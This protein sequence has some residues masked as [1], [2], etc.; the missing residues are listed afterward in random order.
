MNTSH[1]DT[2]MTH[3]FEGTPRIRPTLRSARRARPQGNRLRWVSAVAAALAIVVGLSALP[4]NSAAA[5]TPPEDPPSSTGVSPAEPTSA[6]SLSTAL[7]GSQSEAEASDTTADPTDAQRVGEPAQT[8]P[9][10]TAEPTD[11]LAAGEQNV[12]SLPISAEPTD[13]ASTDVVTTEPPT[14]E[15][16]P[17]DQTTS[18]A[19]SVE[20]AP[21]SPPTA[22]KLSVTNRQSIRVTWTYDSNG[23]SGFEIE[24]GYPSGTGW[25]P[26]GTVAADVFVFDDDVSDLTPGNLVA[27]RVRA[28]AGDAVSEWQSG[29]VLLEGPA[30]APSSLSEPECD[31]SYPTACIPAP[32][33][34]LDC[35]DIVE[36]NF[37]VMGSDPH[38]FDSDGDGIGC[39]DVS[40]IEADGAISGR[41][42]DSSGAP[43][44]DVSVSADGDDGGYGSSTTD[45]DGRYTIVG[46]SDGDYRVEFWPY[47][48]TLVGEY[49]N[50][51]ASYSAATLVAVTAGDTATGIDAVLEQGG[52]ISGRVTDSSGAPLV[53]VSV[54]ADSD[55]GGYGSSTTDADGR[56]TIVG[57]SDG[58]YR[59]RFRP[60][61][62]SNFV[63]EYYN[64]TTDYEAATL[65][66]VTAGDTATGIDAVLAQGGAISGRV[67][68][69]SGAPL[70][71]VDV[72]A[73]GDGWGY[74]STDADGRYTI[75]GLSDGDYRVEFWPYD[76]TLVGEYY[77]DTT[78]YEA[79]TLVAVTAGDTATGID[80]VLTEDGPPSATAPSAPLA[81]SAVAANGAAAV[82][83]SA[84]ADGG[85][86]ITSYTVTASPGG[87]T[88]STASLT[89]TVTGLTNGTAYSFVVRA[90]N[91]IGTGLASA[92][93]NT[94][95][96]SSAPSSAILSGIVTGP[97]G[98]PIGNATIQA[99]AEGWVS[100]SDDWYST[101]TDAAG[102]YTLPVP[103][104]RYRVL[105]IPQSGSPYFHEYFDNTAYNPDAA[106]LVS[107][108]AGEQRGGINAQLD[109]AA[110]FSGRVTGPDGKPVAGIAVAALND[111]EGFGEKTDADGRYRVRV[112]PGSYRIRFL[113][114]DGSVYL[115]EYFENDPSFYTA[116][117][118][119]FAPGEQ[120]DGID[121]VLEARV[122][123]APRLL[124]ST[125]APTS[126]VGSGQ[127][128]LSWDAPV[129]DGGFSI[130]DYVIQRSTSGV[131]WAT[132][133]DGVSTTRSVTV[134]G[135]TNGTTYQ[136]RV[137]ASNAAGAGAWANTT[138]TPRTVPSAP[139]SLTATVA[140]SGGVG[141]GQV[142]LS[143][144]AP[145]SAGGAALTSYVIEQSL[146]GN[147][148][149]GVD[150]T[151]DPAATSFTVSG[152]TNGTTYQFRVAASNAAGVSAYS[153]PVSVTPLGMP[154]APR[155]LTSTVAPTSGVGSGQ[156]R[157]TWTAP[158]ASGGSA[159]TDYVIQRSRTS[160][161]N[162]TTVSDGVRTT[163]SYTVSGLSNGVRYYFRIAAKNAAGAGSFTS[164]INATPRT[165]P[166]MPRSLAASAGS[167]QVRLT[168]TA[169]SASGGSAVTDYVIQRS[170]TG[171]SNWTTV[172]DGVRTRTSYTVSG[173]RNGVRY[174]FR[175]AAK[176]AVG[177]S[178]FSPATSV[179]PHR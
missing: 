170:R 49:Y 71:D 109:L 132:V 43:V 18:T 88:C 11:P 106:T 33:P 178:A 69:S 41:V 24:R 136:F 85:S 104:G 163:T 97:S 17:T 144:D 99:Y 146:D 29:S 44:V 134:S 108:T 91:A 57:L 50:N 10:T 83:W 166:S 147:S 31:P 162:W 53:D 34:D 179:I 80:A 36:S 2:P 68:D 8:S 76:S 121:A 5:G 111:L 30:A 9:T 46:L 16:L 40:T 100:G 158:A 3:S 26:V 25:M 169:P 176:N 160:S 112:R 58:D 42:T 70:A 19:A 56:Y 77:N 120:R 171:S 63:R 32:P 73:D 153:S 94:V 64:D 89:C 126:G 117:W 37:T 87:R 52:S 125:V 177:A 59:V 127:V 96:P 7:S 86:P 82:S 13:P 159:V 51:A 123:S 155:L 15:S 157:L 142:R 75:V 84:P 1:P 105:F 114:P 128:R 95:T 140:P 28:V 79:A 135:L 22:L 129:S 152:L 81:V 119:T 116:K 62:E 55:D 143:W 72:Y 168:W 47:E 137:A 23:Q 60:S 107:V 165:V 164:V 20:S 4:V 141:S 102:R 124:T 161:S 167:R 93:S 78:D 90:T 150:D 138:G 21:L 38:H 48:S 65:V 61:S 131:A 101:R 39:D 173:L 92:Q 154:S 6:G 130:T 14:T 27:Y 172:S 115:T 113:P 118:L 151:V 175:V 110:T 103:A 139:Q 148:W 54:S 174:Y 35:A 74:A 66:A 133:D 156:V 67:T 145:A 12:E 122:P 98:E 45:A 149:V